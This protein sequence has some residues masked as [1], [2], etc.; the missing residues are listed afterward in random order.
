MRIK[1]TVP[2]SPIPAAATLLMSSAF[3]ANCDPLDPANADDLAFFCAAFDTTIKLD[4][5]ALV[6]ANAAQEIEDNVNRTL[7]G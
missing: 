3:F 7:R 6:K 2:V 1:I 5:A 4:V